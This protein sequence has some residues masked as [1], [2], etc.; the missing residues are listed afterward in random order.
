MPKVLQTNDYTKIPEYVQKCMSELTGAGFEVWLVGGSVRDFLMGR[1]PTDYDL[2]TD[3]SPEE[4]MDVFSGRKIVPTGIQHGTI[5]VIINDYPVEITTYRTEGAY[6]D[7]RR[8]DSVEYTRSLEQ[9][10]LRRD[11]TV[12]ALVMNRE[13]KVCDYTGGLRDLQNH[14]IRCVG[15]PSLRFREDALRILRAL[16]FASTLGFSIEKET[17]AALVAEKNLL[18]N[19]AAERVWV[20]WTG[21]LCGENV[22]TIMEMYF[23]VF[24]EII[25]EMI[26]MRHFEQHN[27]HHKYDVWQHTIRVIESVP[28]EKE[29]RLAAFFHDIGKPATFSCGEDGIGHFYGHEAESKR[30]ASEVLLRMRSDTQTRQAVEKLVALHCVPIEPEEKMIRRR[31]NQH[32]SKTVRQLLD[33]KKADVMAQS[34]QNQYRLEHIRKTGEMLQEISAGNSCLSRKELVV[35]GEDLIALGIP[36]GREIGQWLERILDKVIDGELENEK[37]TILQYISALQS[38]KNV[39]G[40]TSDKFK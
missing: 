2:A 38:G 30:I 10:L 40:D 21:I 6:S 7:G 14:I 37:E 33:L 24:A 12:N 29:L 20:E 9:D 31:L 18:R 5:T 32:G 36:A 15:D 35:H 3:A 13:G 34:A 27:P 39:G 4:M 17:A 8:P 28:P 19:I 26:P 23:E 16:R 25:P 22:R 11:F 1:I